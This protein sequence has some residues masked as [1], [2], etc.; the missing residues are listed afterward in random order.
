METWRKWQLLLIFPHQ[1]FL[2]GKWPPSVRKGKTGSSVRRVQS[3]SFLYYFHSCIGIF[4]EAVDRLLFERVILHAR[5]RSE[6]SQKNTKK[7][8]VIKKYG[9][10]SFVYKAVRFQIV[11]FITFFFNLKTPLSHLRLNIITSYY[12]IRI[13]FYQKIAFTPTN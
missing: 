13:F 7:T 2:L 6:C 12:K 11:R 5:F 4:L 10:V 3:A 9:A 1:D 8:Q